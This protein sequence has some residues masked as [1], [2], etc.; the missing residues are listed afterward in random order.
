MTNRK[1]PIHWQSHK[2]ANVGASGTATRRGRRLRGTIVF[3]LTGAV[4]L[5]RLLL[6]R[7]RG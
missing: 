2:F 7:L 1:S 4:G 6:R 5:Q 3:S